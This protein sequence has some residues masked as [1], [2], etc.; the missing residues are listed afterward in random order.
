MALACKMLVYFIAICFFMAVWYI[1]LSFRTFS[2]FCMLYR[3]KSGNPVPVASSAIL[4][5][6]AAFFVLPNIAFS[7]HDL[8]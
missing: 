7:Q 5:K 8:L 2:R 3:E 1:L 6:S 4:W